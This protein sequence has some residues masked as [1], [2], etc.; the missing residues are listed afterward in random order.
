MSQWELKHVDIVI[1]KISGR[2]NLTC[3]I[4]LGNVNKEIPLH[5]ESSASDQRFSFNNNPLIRAKDLWT[6]NQC[7]FFLS[8]YF[9]A[10]QWSPSA[11]SVGNGRVDSLEGLSEK[12]ILYPCTI[13]L[14]TRVLCNTLNYLLN[15]ITVPGG[16]WQY[17]NLTCTAFLQ[18]V[19]RQVFPNLANKIISFP[20]INITVVH[21]NKVCINNKALPS[22]CHVWFNQEYCIFYRTHR[23]YKYILCRLVSIEY[24]RN[25][26]INLYL[27]HMR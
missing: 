4:G 11:T 19:L 27:W 26:Y 5:Q 8:P 7:L 23:L 15:R 9:I 1:N 10:A 3:H 6:W 22:S 24:V 17:S 18:T 21:V 25:W 14:M 20:L 13:T 16:A 2:L 12:D